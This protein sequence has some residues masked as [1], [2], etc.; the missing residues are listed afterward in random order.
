MRGSRSNATF[1]AVCAVFIAIKLLFELYAGDFPGKDQALAFSWPLVLGGIGFGVAGLLAER[2]LGL[3]DWQGRRAAVWAIAS[4]VVYGCI[5][6]ASDVFRPGEASPI[7]KGSGSIHLALP[8]SI[9]FYTFGAIF[10]EFFLRLGLLCGL[11]WIIHVALLRRRAFRPVFWTVNAA[12]AL[13]EVLPW[14]TRD[15]QRGQ[16]GQAALALGG[17][18]YLSNVFEGWLLLRFGW[19]TPILF[20]LAFYAVWHVL[21][22]GVFAA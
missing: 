18:L 9:P 16:W 1:V 21:Y 20:R 8:W 19:L 4:G 3:P 17:P 5:T 22:G 11:V 15:A 13:Y 12:V 14:M 6:V 10:L 2:S 7:A